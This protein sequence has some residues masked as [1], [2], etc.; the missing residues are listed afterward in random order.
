MQLMANSSEE[1][2]NEGLGWIPGKVIK[3]KNTN[4]RCPHVGWNVACFS[5][6]H[7]LW[8]GISRESFFYYIHSYYFDCE[9][10]ENILSE[11]EYG[12]RFH[13]SIQRNNILGVQFHPEKSLESGKALLKNFMNI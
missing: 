4:F 1:G 3:F 9:F 2:Y 6:K 7:V 10:E 11:T 12:N 13:S 8:E 5:K